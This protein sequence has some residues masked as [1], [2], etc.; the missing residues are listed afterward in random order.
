MRALYA[1]VTRVSKNSGIKEGSNLS[2]KSKIPFYKLY[3]MVNA[4]NKKHYFQNNEDRFA[5]TT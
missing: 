3:H 5:A 1:A 2:F 4:K